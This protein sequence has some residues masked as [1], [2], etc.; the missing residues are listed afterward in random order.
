MRPD[1]EFTAVLEAK[2]RCGATT[3]IE[4][5]EATIDTLLHAA[6]EEAQDQ[7]WASPD[8]CDRCTEEQKKIEAAEFRADY[9]REDP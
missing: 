4:V 3:H 6:D 8:L 7:G 2:C 1:Q 9:D 5:S